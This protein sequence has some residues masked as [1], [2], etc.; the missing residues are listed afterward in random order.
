[1]LMR[2]T[3]YIRQHGTEQGHTKRLNPSCRIGNSTLSSCSFSLILQ[4]YLYYLD[5]LLTPWWKKSLTYRKHLYLPQCLMMCWPHESRTSRPISALNI[6]RSLSWVNHRL[7]E[8]Q[9]L[10]PQFK[11]TVHTQGRRQPT[12]THHLKETG[13]VRL[14]ALSPW[15][16]SHVAFSM[17]D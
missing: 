17:G 15:S 3:S 7:N 12:R 9:Q 4:H 2:Q 1:M 13:I 8:I 11:N 10:L 5:R 16:K 14:T 6:Y